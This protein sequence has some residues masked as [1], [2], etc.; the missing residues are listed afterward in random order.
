MPSLLTTASLY[1]S[2]RP[3]PI[4]CGHAL[5][6]NSAAGRSFLRTP[7]DFRATLLAEPSF[8]RFTL[9]KAKYF[10]AAKNARAEAMMVR[11]YSQGIILGVI[12]LFIARGTHNCNN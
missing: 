1:R 3:Y 2:V 5:I 4:S 12:P 7:E 11:V 10:P 8:P 9:C 6:I